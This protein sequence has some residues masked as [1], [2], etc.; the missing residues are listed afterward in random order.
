MCTY[1]PDTFGR[2]CI[3]KPV[4][5]MQNARH[6]SLLIWNGVHFCDGRGVTVNI[7]WRSANVIPESPR[8]TYSAGTFGRKNFFNILLAM[9]CSRHWSFQILNRVLFGED[10][11]D[12]VHFMWNSAKVDPECRCVLTHLIHLI[13]NSL[14]NASPQCKIL[15]IDHFRSEMEYILVKK[16][17]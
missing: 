14:A 7:T 4:S 9:Q 11:G 10:R 8:E 17:E 12:T 13:E 16:E 3:G 15:D 2:E 5:T 6:W 1:S